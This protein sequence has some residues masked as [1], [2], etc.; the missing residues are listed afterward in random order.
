M[1]A[2]VLI[3]DDSPVMRASVKFALT[4]AGLEVAEASD[5][6]NGLEVL[7][8]MAGRAE[9]PAMII[10]DVNMPRM[11]GLT[12]VREVKKTGFKFVPI[13]VLTTESQAD[14]KQEG[15]QAG[16]AGWLVKPFTPQQLLDV[17]KKFVR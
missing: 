5:G 8:A 14:K 17:V 3:V 9:K 1:P 4:S 10:T 11:D 7:S 6:Q 16:A 15:K 12:F 13:L 2:K